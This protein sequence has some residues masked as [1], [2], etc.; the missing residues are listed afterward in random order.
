MLTVKQQ[1]DELMRRDRR[2]EAA[3]AA[4]V[5]VWDS[6]RGLDAHSAPVARRVAMAAAIVAADQLLAR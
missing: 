3:I 2:T 5:A 6:W 4:Y 1:E